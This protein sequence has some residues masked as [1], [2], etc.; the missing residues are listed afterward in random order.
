[1]LLQ[2]CRA[3]ELLTKILQDMSVS[4]VAQSCHKSTARDVC[5]QGSTNSVAEFSQ[6]R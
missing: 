2:L 5:E 4:R 6:L 3:A 1:M